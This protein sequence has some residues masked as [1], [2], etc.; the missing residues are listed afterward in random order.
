M[1]TRRRW[2]AAMLSLWGTWR[3]DGSPFVFVLSRSGLMVLASA[4]WE[5]FGAT[6]TRQTFI[7]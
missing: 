2:L 7:F 5:V 1:T 3:Q 6:V 4:L